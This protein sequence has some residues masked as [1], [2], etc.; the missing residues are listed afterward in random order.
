MAALAV[1]SDYLLRH[2]A[3]WNPPIRA[4]IALTPSVPC[5]HYV[6]SWIRVVRGMDELQRRIQIESRLAALL[7]T[8]FV[9]TTI[10]VLNNYGIAMPIFRRG[11]NLIETLILTFAFWKVSSAVINRRYQ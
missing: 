5:L 10:N 4:I 1:V 2:D 11:L 7:G 3:D 8:L 6:R 9:V